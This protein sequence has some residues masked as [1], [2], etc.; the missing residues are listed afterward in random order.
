M[1]HATLPI[2]LALILSVCMIFSGC[3]NSEPSG[4]RDAPT[5]AP[6]PSEEKTSVPTS[7]VTTI[8]TQEIKPSIFESSVS[9][10]PDD[11][12]VYV[13][14]Q[15]DPVYDLITVTFNG[16]KG[17]QL[18]SG[19]DIKFVSSNGSTI[20]TP[21]GINKGDEVT[22]P[23]T[24]GSDRIEAAAYYKNGASYLIVDQLLGSTRTKSTTDTQTPVPSIEPKSEG[25]YSGPVVE[26]PNNLMISVDVEKD[27]V[28]RVITTTFRGGH[29][30]SLVK[31]INVYAILSDGNEVEKELSNNIGGIAEIQGTSGLDKVQVVVVYKNG[32]NY[33]IE[34]KVLGPRG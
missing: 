20:E 1:N 10:P 26:P 11:L 19:L 9:V 34:D 33:K 5:P 18:L 13:S 31:K 12:E 6:V 24:K 23:G 32:E 4:V 29:G 28:Y 14:L 2:I 21:L 25:G 3:T 7:V 16:G 22:L 15:K 8:P 30:Q 17:Q 27:P